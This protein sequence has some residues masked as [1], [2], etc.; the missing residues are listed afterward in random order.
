MRVEIAETVL[1]G[2]GDR[3]V[4]TGRVP[5]RGRGLR[6]KR[7]TAA[8]GW[9]PGPHTGRSAKEEDRGGAPVPTASSV[10]QTCPAPEAEKEG[11]RRGGSSAKPTLRYSPAWRPSAGFR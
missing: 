4:A 1:A 6:S 11:I 3:G 5:L 2:L 7:T 9:R 8:S 10:R